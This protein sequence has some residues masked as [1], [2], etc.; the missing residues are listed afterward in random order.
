MRIG[1]QFSEKRKK[2]MQ[3]D[4]E[5]FTPAAEADFTALWQF[6]YRI[7][8]AELKMRP[9]NQERFLVD[10]FHHKNIYRAARRRQDG[11]LIGMISAHWQPP[12]SAEDHFGSAAVTPPA[13]GKLAEIRLFSV[14]PEY[15]KTAVTTSLGIS[16]LQELEKHQI[17]EIVISGISI[18]KKFYERL[19][20]QVIGEPVPAGDTLLYP[21][22]I[23][24]A[25]F[26]EMC[27][28]LNCYQ[29]C[30]DNR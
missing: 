1:I 12:F 7:F 5:I 23:S 26:L 8:A 9:E 13:A 2:I 21:M 17:S 4:F 6:N 19:G 25:P 27:R 29:L 22:R 20:F 18:Q 16:L 3:C 10:K 28:K 15:R 11:A 24:L 14:A 30:S